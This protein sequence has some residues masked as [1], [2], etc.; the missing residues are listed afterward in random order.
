MEMIVGIYFT[1]IST[2]DGVALS[3]GS[4]PT[5]SELTTTSENYIKLKHKVNTFLLCSILQT[6]VRQNILP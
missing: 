1:F 4:N 5:F 2:S 6:H 3:R